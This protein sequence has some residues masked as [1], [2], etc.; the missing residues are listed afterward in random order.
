MKWLW[1]FIAVSSIAQN[2]VIYRKYKS[3][4]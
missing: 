4:H 3:I 2:V 1:I